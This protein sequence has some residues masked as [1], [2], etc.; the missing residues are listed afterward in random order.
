MHMCMIIFQLFLGTFIEWFKFS[1][2]YFQKD[3]TEIFDFNKTKLANSA[4]SK[5]HPFQVRLIALSS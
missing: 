1:T 2:Y 3:L 5:C 4:N